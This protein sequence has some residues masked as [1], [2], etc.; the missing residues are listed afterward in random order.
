MLLNA[1]PLVYKSPPNSLQKGAA[2]LVPLDTQRI[3]FKGEVGGGRVC[4]ALV[5]GSR[6]CYCGVVLRVG[7]VFLGSRKCFMWGGGVIG[8]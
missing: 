1:S 6:F 4:V 2:Q 3:D 8:L 7:L 5:T